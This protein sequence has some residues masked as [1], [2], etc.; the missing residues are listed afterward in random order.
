LEEL[1]LLDWKRRVGELYAAVRAAPDPAEG[2]VQW[3]EVRR[4]LF[5]E[6]AQSPVPPDERAAFRGPHVFDYDP[7]WRLLAEVEPAAVEHLELPSSDG[8]TMAFRRF[9]RAR[10]GEIT[11]DLYWLEGYGGGMFV[12][13]RDATSGDET[14]GAGRYI[15]DTVKGADL[16]AAGSRLIL[17]F[18]FAYQPSCSYDPRWTCPLA[19]PANRL[20]LEI[21]AGERLTAR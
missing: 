1:D 16:G 20:E 4:L 8:A 14:Y 5:R 3:C 19:P 21:R 9:G 15:L 11:L 2:W 7:A 18:N 12:P 17:D 13:F 10:A 6:H